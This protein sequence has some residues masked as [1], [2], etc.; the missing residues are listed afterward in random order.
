MYIRNRFPWFSGHV[1][2]FHFNER[3]TRLCLCRVIN[4]V[5]FDAFDGVWNVITDDYGN[6]VFVK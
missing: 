6:N 4:D 1:M 5:G 3:A 2:H